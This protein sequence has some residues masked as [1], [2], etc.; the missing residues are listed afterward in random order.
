[1]NMQG[2]MKQMQKMQTKMLAAKDEIEAAEYEGAA[3]SGKVKLM[4]TGKGELR[5]IS[6]DKSVV[7]PEDVELLEDLV[8]TAFK[9]AKAKADAQSAALMESFRMPGIPG[10]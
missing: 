5:S 4:L 8:L 3:G 10:F 7:D 1:M 6:I 2:M 9:D